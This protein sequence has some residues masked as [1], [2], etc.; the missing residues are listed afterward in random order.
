MD[1]SQLF[2]RTHFHE[3]AN[4]LLIISVILLISLL[5]PAHLRFSY[6]FEQGQPWAYKDLHAPFDFSL[7][8]SE[9]ELM[10]ERE[11]ALQ[12][13]SPVYV[14]DPSILRDQIYQFK[15]AFYT[16]LESVSRDPY[17]PFAELVRDPAPYISY[18][19]SYLR[20]QYQRG[21]ILPEEQHLKAGPAF[22]IAVIN[23]NTLREYTLESL[24]DPATAQRMLGDTLPFV[25]LPHTDFLLPLLEEHLKPNLFYDDSITQLMQQEALAGITERKGLVKQGE[26]IVAKGSLVTKETHQKLESFR[27]EFEQQKS[28][29]KFYSVLVGYLLLISLL[30]VTFTVYLKTF[31]RLIYNRFNR[32]LF[33]M[34]WLVLYS[35]LVYVVE[36]VDILS[37]NIIPFCI[38]P[39]VVK[40]F[41][42]ERLALFTHLMVV[43]IAGFLSSLGYNFIFLQLLAGIVV[44]L[45]K[46]DTR[47]WSRFFYSHLFIFLSYLIGLTGLSLI[48]EG[49]LS[50]VNASS[51][52]AIG[53]N[54]FLTL[55]AYP[56]IPLL[57]RM[58]GFTSPMTLVELADMNQPLLRELALR[59]PGT[60]QHS[61]QVAH[62]AEAAARRIGADELTVR[63]GALYHDIGKKINPLFFIENQSGINPHKEI[64]KLDSARIIIGHVEEG[65]Q[66]A[67]KH[68]LPQLIIDFIRTHHGTTRV[69]YFYR[70]YLNENEQADIDESLFRYPG[71][72]PTTK[73][74]TILM[75]ADSLEASC[76][77]LH[78]PTGN[79]I[80]NLV[81]TII[82]GKLHLKQLEDSQL[83]FRE[84]QECKIVFRQILRSI[85]H[86]RIQYP[87]AADPDPTK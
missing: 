44:L 25:K 69:E 67:K 74:E 29:W 77:S 52:T 61:L 86:E 4:T 87:K 20:R 53:L 83:S 73:E 1:W 23:G 11:E 38:V 80:D 66:L 50:E 28:G 56:L 12:S 59:A 15:E 36:N 8:K 48:Q 39:I 72:R 70:S 82:D 55:S 24:S 65:V 62:L 85:H 47:N 40:T 84:L 7:I 43:L 18:G 34:M 37:V 78:A 16:Q 58:F 42:T 26:L 2:K 3:F 75:L 63:V 51:V 13:V 81:D 31:A 79:D 64:S 32:L 54:V 57:E 19:E 33:I 21:I 68:H 35:Y 41:F 27:Q 49:N 30:V 6:A 71:P 10:R 22:V 76:K 9:E 14:V 5:A 17:N 45:A 60:M 46:V